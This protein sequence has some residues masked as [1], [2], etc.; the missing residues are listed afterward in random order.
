MGRNEISG[1]NLIPSAV[2]S[3]VEGTEAHRGRDTVICVNCRACSS[4]SE[5]RRVSRIVI[6]AAREVRQRC[7]AWRVCAG[8]K[9]VPST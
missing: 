3:C 7:V 1:T 4:V 9:V 5:I 8:K 6:G 2:T